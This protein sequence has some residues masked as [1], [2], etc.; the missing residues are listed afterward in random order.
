M[1]CDQTAWSAAASDLEAAMSNVYQTCMEYEAGI[2]SRE[3]AE[4][5]LTAAQD[6]EAAALAAK[7]SALQVASQKQTAVALEAEKLGVECACPQPPAPA[8]FRRS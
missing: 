2:A 3:D 1:A 5:A 8:A 6:A 7:E 4:R